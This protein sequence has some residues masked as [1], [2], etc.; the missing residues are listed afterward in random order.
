MRGWDARDARAQQSGSAVQR[1]SAQ[2][3]PER[4]HAE[5]RKRAA[6]EGARVKLYNFAVKLRAKGLRARAGERR[7][8]FRIGL[9]RSIVK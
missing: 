6:D 1:G 2:T 4:T 3:Q 9:K 8:S 5:R 7:A